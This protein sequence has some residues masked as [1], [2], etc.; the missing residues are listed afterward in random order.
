[1][2]VRQVGKQHFNVPRA[3]VA[4]QVR[5]V[6]MRNPAYKKVRELDPGTLFELSVKPNPLLLATGMEIAVAENGPGTTVTVTA[7]SQ[8]LMI[9]DAGGFYYR[10]VRDFLMTL[11]NALRTTQGSPVASGAA[12]Y[13]MEVSWAEVAITLLLVLFGIWMAV[14]L[15]MPVFRLF[16]VLAVI[17]AVASLIRIV[18]GGRLRT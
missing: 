1:M 15:R 3:I 12:A 13:K 9:G 6:L 8:A 14:T 16:I 17:A 7:T 4:E 10:Y 11:Q 18:R 2:T 5:T